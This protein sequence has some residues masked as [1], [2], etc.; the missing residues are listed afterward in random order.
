MTVELPATYLEMPRWWHGGHDWLAAL[1][2]A[3][4]DALDRW[5]LTLDGEP[6]HGSNA[7]VLPV[8]R[9]GFP[10]ALRL[11]PPDDDIAAEILALRFWDGRGVV[12]LLDADPERGI[13]LLERLHGSD[14]LASRPLAEAMPTTAR[15]A[16]R[17]AVPAPDTVTSTGEIA[18]ERS[19]SMPVE[20]EELGHPFPRA[21]LDRILD[22][23][24]IL[25]TPD[26]SLAVNGDLH[27]EQILRA[28]REPWLVVDPVLLRGDLA[29]DFARVLWTR[30]DEM[31]A[32]RDIRH[33]LDVLIAESGAAPERARAWARFRTVDY[34][35][36]GLAHG[37][38]ED[39]VRCAHLL[40][41][42][43]GS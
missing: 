6:M 5:Q 32:D 4:D 1:P 30:L 41:A 21:I 2:A 37:L 18:R 13:S 22:E 17:L 33:W 40:A 10:L 27:G 14:T 26:G 42:L 29:Y 7:L 38:T 36:W 16:A 11:T 23:G 35:L 9:E 12:R 28:D 8:R 15:L 43:P 20:W 34:W 39:P 31:P 19:Q 3:I 24:Q 25:T